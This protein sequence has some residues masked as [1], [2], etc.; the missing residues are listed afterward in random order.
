MPK[1]KIIQDP[2][3]TSQKPTQTPI[4]VPAAACGLRLVDAAHLSAMMVQCAIAKQLPLSSFG[5][6]DLE[7]LEGH[8]AKTDLFHVSLIGLLFGL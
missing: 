8:Q 3:S 2:T 6:L 7:V 4:P 1:I 5:F